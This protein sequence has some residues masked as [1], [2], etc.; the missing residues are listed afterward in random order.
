MWSIAGSV[1]QPIFQGGALWFNWKSKKALQEQALQNYRKVILQAL[2]EV[3]DAL[4]ARQ[5]S[6][7]QRLRREEQVGALRDAVRL[8]D[9]NYRAGQSS[10]LDLLDSERQLFAAAVQLEQ[11]R[12][13]ELLSCVRLYKA[14]GGGVQMKPVPV[15]NAAP[16]AKPGAGR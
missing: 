4:V 11:A 3:S 7:E 1:S 2:R 12:L 15:A 16:K 6:T 10:Y 5:Q 13:E 9:L 8:S 14:L